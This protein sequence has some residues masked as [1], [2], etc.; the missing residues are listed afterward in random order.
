MV[1]AVCCFFCRHNMSMSMPAFPEAYAA[2][3]VEDTEVVVVVKVKTEGGFSKD[4]KRVLNK[5]KKA[6]PQENRVLKCEICEKSGKACWFKTLGC[7][8]TVHTN[9]IMHQLASWNRTC[10]CPKCKVPYKGH[11]KW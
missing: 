1:C 6:L 8:H 5:C 7:G 10:I 2:D 4:E 3:M 11:V 9:C